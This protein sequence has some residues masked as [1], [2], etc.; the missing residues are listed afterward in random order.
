MQCDMCGATG[1]IYRAE[2][3]GTELQ[4]CESC[5][6]L[7]RVIGRVE[8]PEALRR[9]K[10]RP[11]PQERPRLPARRNETIQVIVDG[12]AGI[13]KAARERIGLKQKELAM[14]IAE[15][16][17]L[18]HNIESGHFEPG[19]GL[20]RKLERFL[21]VSLIEDHE[22]THDGAFSAGGEDVTLGDVIRI[23]RRG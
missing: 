20:A 5:A 10:A 22:E 3:E 19:I 14:R 12:Y 18:I 11:S 2:I 21:K 23:K 15:K 13:V 17:S 4:V 8:Q 16:E 9:R 6:S 7:G 1:E